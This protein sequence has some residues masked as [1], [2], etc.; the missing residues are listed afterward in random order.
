MKKSLG[1]IFAPFIV[2]TVLAVVSFAQ[3]GEHKKPPG[4]NERQ[5]NQRDR[6]KNG[7]QDGEINQKE[8]A[9]LAKEQVK[10]RQQERRFRSDGELSRVERARVQHNLNQSSRHIHRAKN[11]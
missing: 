5:E 9:R 2:M 1:F 7:V 6:I 10:I 4:I 8:R 3:E 11:N